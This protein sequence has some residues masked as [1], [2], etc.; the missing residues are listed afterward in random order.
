MY[1]VSLTHDILMM[2]AGFE[3]VWQRPA[4][5]F[6]GKKCYREIEKRSAPCP[7]CPGVIALRTGTV[8]EAEAYAT[9]DDGT[10]V[11]FLLRAYPLYGLNGEPA[12]FVE[13]AEDI[14]GRR[15]F[16]DDARHEVSLVN[17]LLTTSSTSRILKLGLDA[18]LR[19]EGV[20]SGCVYT[21]DPATGVRG[22]VAQRGLMPTEEEPADP[23][24]DADAP[25]APQG[26][27]PLVRMPIGQNGHPAAELVVR[28]SGNAQLWPSIRSKIEAM[29]LMLAS[30][31]ARIRE[32][33]LRGDAVVNVQT[34][35]SIVPLA[36]FFLD[37]RGMVTLWNEE[38]ERTFGWTGKDALGHA[39]P[40]VCGGEEERF[41]TLVAEAAEASQAQRFKFPCLD[42]GGA[43]SDVWFKAAAVRDVIGDGSAYLV[44]AA[45]AGSAG[46]A[47]AGTSPALEIAGQ[48][49][50]QGLGHLFHAISKVLVAAQSPAGSAQS[51]DPR[52]AGAVA[53]GKM[54]LSWDDDGA[55]DIH[56]CVPAP[57]DR[58]P[59][60]NRPSQALVI[61]RDQEDGG[62]LGGILGALGYSA[63]VCTS[64][65][66]AL[67]HLRVWQDATA[68]L[69]LAIVDMVMPEGP[70]G[71]ETARLLT[72]LA[73]GLRVVVSSERGVVGHR[74]HGFAA[75]L[76]RPYTDDK[77]RS[78]I[79]AA[80]ELRAV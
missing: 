69:R 22:L 67:E 36:A 18:A 29:A 60:E 54:S 62:R 26:D 31:L 51:A 64:V 9:L 24:D 71:V 57:E 61:Q 27:S 2:N 77:V 17:D 42:R 19:L 79:T 48:P 8:A 20:D 10:R 6:L 50:T 40:I 49:D 12:G 76:S 15:R 68:P 39:P 5:S 55:V 13:T 75:A 66:T 47:E 21:L 43:T 25:A 63:T 11:P 32:E 23:A 52:P 72:A 35:L 53:A 3:A 59:G 74:A 78:A 80:L 65:P 16:E 58:S 33:R 7:H 1:L 46:S 44:V 70:D 37:N 56:V 30:A 34:V 38:A 14:S 73:P 28:L 41:L 45:E 4:S